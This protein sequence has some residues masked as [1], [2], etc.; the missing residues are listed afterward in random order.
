MRLG[1]FTKVQSFSQSDLDQFGTPSLITRTTNDVNQIQQ[2]MQLLLRTIITTP[3]F[4]LGG[5]IMCLRQDVKLS[6][7]LLFVGQF[8]GLFVLGALPLLVLSA[9]VLLLDW[10]LFRKASRSFTPEKLLK[11]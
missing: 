5:I 10:L 2:M 7:I 11:K 3:I 9:V 4:L 6:V 1:L 8:T